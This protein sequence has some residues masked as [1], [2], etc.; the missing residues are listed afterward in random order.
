M[1]SNYTGLG[2]PFERYS[3]E[4]RLIALT[5]FVDP[6]MPASPKDWGFYHACRLE[7]AYQNVI[8]TWYN[9]A[10]VLY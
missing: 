3:G 4:Y 8:S 2:Y 9:R 5:A 7:A 6:S 10:P 1:S